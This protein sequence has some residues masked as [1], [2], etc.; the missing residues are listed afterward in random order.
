MGHK[1]GT[2][3]VLVEDGF[4]RSKG[5][6]AD[7]IPPLSLVLDDQGIYYDATRPSRLEGLIADAPKLTAT[8][9]SRATALIA[10][11]TDAGLSKY[12]LAGTAMP[13][14]PKGRRILVP[15]QVTDDAS[16]KFGTDDIR[17]NRALLQATRAAN[18][19]ATIIYKPHPDVMAGLRDGAVDDAAEFADIILTDTDAI[20]AIDAVDEVWTMT[21]LLGFEALLRGKQVTCFGMP[22]YAGWGLTDDRFMPI[23][24]RD[25]RVDLAG[26]VHAALIEY[27]RYFDPVTGTPCPPEVVIDRIENNDVP[28]PRIGNR[29]LAKVQGLCASYAHLWRR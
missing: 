12:N 29:A 5:L 28:V 17:N 27:P 11:I 13:D 7:L 15:G 24:R 26:L 9:R 18:N 6:G 1:G 21:S 23:E 25:T 2:E 10:R 19:A 8:E 22:F 20:A 14:L 16:I 3:A 4:L